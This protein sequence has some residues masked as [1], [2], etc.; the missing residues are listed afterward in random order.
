MRIISVAI[1]LLLFASSAAAQVPAKM[2]GAPE[3]KAPA[4]FK[5]VCSSNSVCLDMGGPVAGRSNMDRSKGLTDLADRAQKNL[6]DPMKLIKIAGAITSSV[7]LVLWSLK[8]WA[9]AEG[10]LGK[11]FQEFQCIID[12]VLATEGTEEMWCW[13]DRLEAARKPLEKRAKSKK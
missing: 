3:K 6:R 11:E 4:V 12:R 1:G 5:G 2:A 8:P 10:E 7:S 9:K 13:M